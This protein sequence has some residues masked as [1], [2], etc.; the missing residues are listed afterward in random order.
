MLASNKGRVFTNEQIYE[1]L[2][3]EDYQYL[4]DDI[5]DGLLL[6]EQ[7]DEAILP[8]YAEAI[9]DSDRPN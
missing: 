7:L 8:Q 1:K 9:P 2:W 4:L 6:E 5:R 3:D